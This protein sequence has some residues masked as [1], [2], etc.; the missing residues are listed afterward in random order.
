MTKESKHDKMNN[1]RLHFIGE[2][3]T[4]IFCAGVFEK[5]RLLLIL[6]SYEKNYNHA[7]FQSVH[8]L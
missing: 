3:K 1:L 8:P 5:T 7:G 4:N 6:K 2:N